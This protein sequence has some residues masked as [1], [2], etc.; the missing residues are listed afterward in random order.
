MGSTAVDADPTKT[1]VSLTTDG[2]TPASVTVTTA[3][4]WSVHGLSNQTRSD[5]GKDSGYI[6][7][8]G[9]QTYYRGAVF[10]ANLAIHIRRIQAD[11]P[12][13]TYG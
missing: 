12:L 2:T 1:N 8:N 9:N 13:G 11:E 7:T 4:Y 6:G 5:I 3:N 10:H